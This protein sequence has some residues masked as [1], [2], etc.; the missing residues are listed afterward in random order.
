MTIL[1]LCTRQIGFMYPSE[2]GTSVWIDIYEDIICFRAY[3]SRR[4]NNN[5]PQ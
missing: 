4:N 5:I 1:R 2:K 3:P